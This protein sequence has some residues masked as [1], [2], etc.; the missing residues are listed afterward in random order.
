MEQQGKIAVFDSGVG[1]ISF[2]HLAKKMLPEEDFLFYG[3]LANAPYGEK[4]TEFIQTRARQIIEFLLARGAKIIVIACNTATSAAVQY[5][6]QTYGNLEILGMEP[7][8]QL[9]V[10]AGE[11]QILLLSTAITAHAPN[12]LRLIRD[13]AAK[14]SVINIPCPGLMDLV[15][16]N[17]HLSEQEIQGR[18]QAYLLE[19]L[20]GPAARLTEGGIVLG[21]THYV[22][23]RP[24]LQKLYPNF[25]LYDGNEGTARNLVRHLE[26]ANLRNPKK[27]TG[28]VTF[29]TSAQ[30][31]VFCAKAAEF[32]QKLD[33]MESEQ[34]R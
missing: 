32:W 8:I 34:P 19:K 20:E 2:L 5:L 13:N 25:R 24:L 21:C 12:T 28:S 16:N 11:K 22:F 7:A 9:A 15:E 31:E 10:N 18:L 3:D 23:L 27:E 30:P 14:A 33:V 1:G 26:A 29:Y 4:S 6:R 17:R